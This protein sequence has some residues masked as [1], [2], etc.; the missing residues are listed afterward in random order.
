MRTPTLLAVAHGTGD[1]DGLASVRRLLTRVRT[2]RPEIAVELA[3]LERAEP[4]LPFA[5]A[6][7]IGPVV[8]VPLLLSTGYH[9]KVDITAAVVDRPE[10]AVARQLGPDD[11]IVRVLA[12]RLAAARR[13]AGEEGRLVEDRDECQVVLFGAGSTDPEAG[14]QLA[15]A[16]DGLQQR[17]GMRVHW[18]S[19]GQREAWGDGLPE[20]IEVANYLLAP[21]HFN[22]LLHQRGQQLGSAVVAAPLGEHPLLAELV[23]DR[24]DEAVAKLTSAVG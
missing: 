23:W 1:P 14:E 21:G 20:D 4:T 24:Y 22:D 9:V 5:L 18:R 8:L 19:L 12:E 2:A 10:T 3:W 15:A 6:G 11:R 13:A 16:A 17:I 7:L